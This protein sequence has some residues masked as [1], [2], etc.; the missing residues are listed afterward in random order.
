MENKTSSKKVWIA[1]IGIIIVI[2]VVWFAVSPKSNNNT[3]PSTTTN[4]P[5]ASTSPS[6]PNT[7]TSTNTTS[8]LLSE[9]AKHNKSTDCW[10][11]INGSVVDVT[12]FIVSGKHNPK[13]I[14]AC[15]L[16]TTTAFSQ[17]SKHGTPQVQTLFKEFTIGKLQS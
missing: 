3:A 5:I 15:G 7:T 16:E 17:V 6:V 4:Q 1:I 8:Y 2:V 11:A 12:K 10:I 9:V 13:I 14:S